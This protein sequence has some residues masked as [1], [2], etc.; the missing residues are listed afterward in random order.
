M[1]S[2]VTCDVFSK[3]QLER[4]LIERYDSHIVCFLLRFVA[5]IMFFFFFLRAKCSFIL[6][7]KWYSDWET[8]VDVESERRVRSA[9]KLIVAQICDITYDISEC[10]ASS[11]KH[12]DE[13]SLVPLLLQSLMSIL[14]PEKL[15]RAA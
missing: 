6:C 3:T 13:S 14:V 5:V 8:D 1:S 9:A 7:D 15:K 4:K 10:Q 11:D 2:S 12:A